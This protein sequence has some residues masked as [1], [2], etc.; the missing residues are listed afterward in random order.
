MGVEAEAVEKSPLPYPWCWHDL[1]CL[2]LLR[3]RKGDLWSIKFRFLLVENYKTN[4]Q[5]KFPGR[6]VNIKE[7][8]KLQK[9]TFFVLDQFLFI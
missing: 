8:I 4:V 7:V 9:V 6:W 5:T 3:R 2:L 1:S